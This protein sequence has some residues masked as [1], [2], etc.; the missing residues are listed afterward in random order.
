M[1]TC[2]ASRL[3]TV[4]PIGAR[5]TATAASTL[6][7]PAEA[8]CSD[9]ARQH[10]KKCW[11]HAYDRFITLAN[12]GDADAARLALFMHHYGPQLYGSDEDPSAQEVEAWTQLAAQAAS[13]HH[14][15]YQPA[16]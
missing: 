15:A 1:N 2:I 6:G 7:A 10:Q 13:R 5:W 14:P 16:R 12:R 8:G 4:A 9:A 11:S 3:C